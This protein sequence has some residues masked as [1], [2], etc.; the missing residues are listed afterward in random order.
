MSYASAHIPGSGNYIDRAAWDP[1][2]FNAALHEGLILHLARMID[3]IRRRLFVSMS[4]AQTAIAFP[5]E[6]AKSP[7]TKAFSRPEAI[8]H[9]VNKFLNLCYRPEKCAGGPGY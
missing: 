8:N 3:T 6:Y 5:A 1:P 4:E 7:D 9:L 2:V